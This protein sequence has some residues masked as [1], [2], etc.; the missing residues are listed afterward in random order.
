MKLFLF[1]SVY[2]VIR[3]NASRLSMRKAIDSYK[4]NFNQRLIIPIFKLHYKMFI[5]NSTLI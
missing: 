5:C 1:N 2:E 3:T 4:G